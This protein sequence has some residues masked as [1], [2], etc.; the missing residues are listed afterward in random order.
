VTAIQAIPPF[1]SDFAA[2]S[3]V[4]CAYTD[5]RRELLT[6]CI[7]TI[8]DQ[9]SS[10]DELVLVID[11]NDELYE[12]VSRQYR[13]TARVVQNKNE[14]GL[15]GAR[16]SGIEAA[17]QE[18][19]AFIDDDA[20]IQPGWLTGLREHYRDPA[21]A[22]VGGS[23][24]PVW[25]GARPAWLPH[26]FDW[27]IGCSYRGLPKHVSPVRNF[28]G[29]NM[30]F[31]RTALKDIGGFSKEIGRVGSIS[32][33]RENDETEVCIRLKQSSPAS[34]L[35]LDPNVA[36]QHWMSHDRTRLSYFL[37]RCFSEGLS[38]YRL[39]TMVGSSDG[40]SDE[41]RYVSKVLP[42]GLAREVI[43]I[44][45]GRGKRVDHLARSLFLIIG[46]AATG[47]GYFNALMRSHIPWSPTY[48]SLSRR[49]QSAFANT[50]RLFK[51][52]RSYKPENEVS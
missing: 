10:E 47:T 23:A 51:S 31:R 16:N 7:E 37:E 15:C 36:V 52:E 44:A 42:M 3:V 29:C 14:R 28:L 21:V 34:R 12:N 30:S 20:Q 27:V 49:R 24:H 8:L 38:K 25:P 4:V 1:A 17:T 33:G 35:L 40:L 11:H 32:I 50:L 43:G 2:V 39:S 45:S 13:S 6:M 46:L 26:E 19:V 9:L 48:S 18:I 41:R 22:G 5:A